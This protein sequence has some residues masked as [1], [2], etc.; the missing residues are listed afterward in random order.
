MYV[1]CVT[2]VAALVNIDLF[3]RPWRPVVK[4]CSLGAR[5]QVLTS[6]GIAAG[7][8]AGLAFLSTTYVAPE[9]REANPRI[10]KADAK[11][12]ATAI[13]GFNKEKVLDM[14]ILLHLAWNTDGTRILL[15][16]SL[17]ICL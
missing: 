17:S 11:G 4:A 2:I 8:D 6:S 5:W 10:Q 13:I 1:H 12:D 3:F 7:I 9:D 14:P 16:I 15:T